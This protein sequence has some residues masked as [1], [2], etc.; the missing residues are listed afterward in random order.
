MKLSPI[1]KKH[2]GKLH[3]AKPISTR[4]I[5]YK[6]LEQSAI[7]NAGEGGSLKMDSQFAYQQHSSVK[8]SKHLDHGKLIP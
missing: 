7:R 1:Q 2:T 8:P 5:P 3:S 6:K 4:K